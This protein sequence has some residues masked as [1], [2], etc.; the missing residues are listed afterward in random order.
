[1]RCAPSNSRS[2]SRHLRGYWF[3]I[4]A[5][6]AAEL[7]A[8]KRMHNRVVTGKVSSM[9]WTFSLE[10]FL[11]FL[12][13]A[14]KIPARLKKPSIGRIDH[15]QGYRP[16]NV[17]WEEHAINS[18]KRKGTRHQFAT[19]DVEFRK[20]LFKRSSP[21][22][23]RWFRAEIKRRWQDPSFRKKHA[24]SLKRAWAQGKFRKR[25]NHRRQK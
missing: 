16:G 3:I 10:G 7:R 15:S 11:A 1:M 9:S 14:G 17:R 22:H 12:K 8:F 2:R 4:N 18:A 6:Y 13:H 21:E 5:E 23:H 25:K 24:T 19:G 20:R